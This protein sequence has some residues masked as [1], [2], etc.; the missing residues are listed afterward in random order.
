MNSSE[1]VNERNIIGDSNFV[2]NTNSWSISVLISNGNGNESF[3][4][5]SWLISSL[6]TESIYSWNSKESRDWSGLSISWESIGKIKECKNRWSNSIFSSKFINESISFRDNSWVTLTGN[7]SERLGNS[8]FI[9]ALSLSSPNIVLGI[10]GIDDIDDILFGDSLSSFGYLDID[11]PGSC[12][13][14]LSNNNSFLSIY[15]CKRG[16]IFGFK[17]I[18]NGS[19]GKFEIE[20]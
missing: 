12:S 4:C 18:I 17:G 6:N 13:L 11:G 14:T 16:E 10:I 19:I 9:I 1:V 2:E 8:S 5:V 20:W 15:W 3:S 7:N